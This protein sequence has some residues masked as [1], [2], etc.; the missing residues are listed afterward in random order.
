M[1]T[2]INGMS[3][4]ELRIRTQ[5]PV[6]APFGFNHP[7]L[8]YEIIDEDTK[9]KVWEIRIAS[10]EEYHKRITDLIDMGAYEH[11]LQINIDYKNKIMECILEEG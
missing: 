6:Y 2:A 11:A 3:A 10:N 5:F 9:D 4:E 7:I 8:T 1:N